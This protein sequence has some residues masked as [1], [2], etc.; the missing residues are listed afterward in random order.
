MKV[1]KS[2]N[3]QTILIGVI[4]SIA[5]SIILLL[6][7]IDEITSLTVGLL[8]IVISLLVELHGANK[9]LE[10][11]IFEALELTADLQKNNFAKKRI[12]KIIRSWGKI[13]EGDLHPLLNNVAKLYTQQAVD[14]LTSIAGGEIHVTSG[15]YG[16]M[17]VI[18]DEAQS[19]IRAL[20]TISLDFWNSNAGRRWKQ[21][22]YEAVKRGIK[23]TRVFL[24]DTVDEPLT[25]LMTEM[26][27]KGI[28]VYL[29]KTDLL[30]KGHHIP[31][32]IADNNLLWIS[33]NSSGVIEQQYFT[34]R[35]E[36][37][38]KHK[39]IFERVLMESEEYQP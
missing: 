32:L 33:D 24:Y 12:A 9:R 30:P 39:N 2:F 20:S 14:Q 37:I 16:W 31:M 1:K 11:K 21:L 10:V 3:N 27:Q 15:D 29:I 36:H 25:I 18:M 13:I 26:Q 7:G 6:L 22:N 8:G 38:L 17:R 23:I 19:D 4:V 34:V 5:S 28:Q 35:E